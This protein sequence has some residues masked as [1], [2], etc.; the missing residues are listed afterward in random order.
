M[1]GTKPFCYGSACIAFG[2]MTTPCLATFDETHPPHHAFNAQLLQ[3][4]EMQ[5]SVVG[6]LKYGVLDTLELGTQAAFLAFSSPRIWNI[7]LKHRMFE[8]PDSFTSFSAHSFFQTEGSDRVFASL[9]GIINSRPLGD[10]SQI[11]SL[12][13]FDGNLMSYSADSHYTVH[14]ITPSIAF[15]KVLNKSWALSLVTLR[16]IYAFGELSSEE[17]GEGNLQV[18]FTKNQ[19]NLAYSSATITYSSDHWNIEFGLVSLTTEL[20]FLPYANLFWRFHAQ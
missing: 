20:L 13:L 15:D 12:G 8:T 18:D 7:S 10:N 6:N 17:A 19:N 4:G 5:A 1:L 16:P 11:L 3:P 14:L 9:H 2:L